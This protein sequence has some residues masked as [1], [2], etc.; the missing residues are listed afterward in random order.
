MD[1]EIIELGPDRL[2]AVVDLCRRALDLPEDAAEAPAI[3]DTLAARA[4]ADR[5]VLRLGAVRG[6]ELIGVLVGSRSGRDRRLGHVDL[7]AVAPEERRR[8]VGRALLAEAERRLAG[9]GAAE[10]LLAGNPPYYAWPG[11]DVRYTPAVCLALRLGYRQDRT[12]WNMTADLA[13]GAPALRTTEPAERRL[14]DQGVTVRRA[15]PADLPALAAFARS[16]FGGAWDGELAGSLGR[17]DA[18]THLAERDGEILG[19][20]AYGSSRPSWFGPMGTAPAA[21]G[22]G[23]GGVLLRRCLRDQAAAGIGTAQIGWVGP[24]PFYANAAGARIERVF[25]LYRKALAGQE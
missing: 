6:T 13:D 4:A 3:V 5:P 24:V 1:A 7:L 10:L 19:F 2:P 12:A 22:S 11:I 9:L 15:E 17:P 20:A 14:A 25:F 21:E 18:G 16:T 8:G 23:I